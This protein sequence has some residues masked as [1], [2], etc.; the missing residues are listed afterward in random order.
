MPRPG[1]DASAQQGSQN[2]IDGEIS[3]D[4]RDMHGSWPMIKGCGML[5]A[6]I[7]GFVLLTMYVFK[8]FF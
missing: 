2:L 1:P 3:F 8:T 7:V 5:I 4:R 6:G